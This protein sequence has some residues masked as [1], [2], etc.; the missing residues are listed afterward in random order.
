M[1]D[2]VDLSVTSRKDS[3]VSTRVPS[4]QQDVMSP[5]TTAM[6]IPSALNMP[7]QL[8]FNLNQL[9]PLGLNLQL[10]LPLMAAA[11]GIPQVLV[12]HDLARIT[13]MRRGERE[14]D[15]SGSTTS[16]RSSSVGPGIHFQMPSQPLHPLQVASGNTFKSSSSSSSNP[17]KRKKEQHMSQ[18]SNHFQPPRRS[19]RPR[20]ERSYA[21]SPDIVV[22]YEEEPPK[23]NGVAVLNGNGVD[24]E[25]ES[26][27][28]PGEMPPLPPEINL[29][30][31][32]ECEQKKVLQRL[33]GQLRNEEMKLV[34][35]KKL[36]LSQQMKENVCVSTTTP[37]ASHNGNIPSAKH[38]SSSSPAIPN[39]MGAP[40]QPPPSHHHGSSHNIQSIHLQ[41][42]LTSAGMKGRSSPKLPPST[43]NL[44]T[45]DGH[46]VHGSHHGLGSGGHH[47]H[48]SSRHDFHGMTSSRSHQSNHHSSNASV[49][50][51]KVPSLLKGQPA[52]RGSSGHHIAPPPP[53]MMAPQR[54]PAGSLPHNLLLAHNSLLRGS[55]RNA[56]EVQQ[57]ASNMMMGFGNNPPG[58]VPP[59]HISPANLA[60]KYDRPKEA[61]T[62]SNSSSQQAERR[63][64]LAT[65]APVEREEERETPAQRQAAA[66]LA[67][68]KQLEKTLLQIPPPKPPPPEMNFI[69][70]PNNME[71]LALVGLEFVVDY[72]TRDPS[73][74]IP[75]PDAFTCS[76]CKTD[77]SS[78]WKWDK[79]TKGK[80]ICEQC[81]TSNVKKSLKAEHTNRLKTAFVKALQ[82]EQEI[83]AR[84][85]QG[86]SLSESLNMGAGTGR[87]G[88]TPSPNTADRDRNSPQVVSSSSVDRS[89]SQS[90][91]MRNRTPTQSP[92]LM[93]L[94]LTMPHAQRDR[95]RERERERERAERAERER[96]REIERE[97]IREQREKEREA[98]RE[99]QRELQ[100][101]QQHREREREQ[102]EREREE[103]VRERERREEREH[104]HAVRDAHTMS[105]PQQLREIQQASAQLQQTLQAQVQAAAEQHA[106]RERE[107]QQR[108]QREHERQQRH[109]SQSKSNQSK[110]NYS[111]LQALQAFR[112]SAALG[113]LNLLNLSNLNVM[114]PNPTASTSSGAHSTSQSS[115]HPNQAYSGSKSRNRPSSSRSSAS[116]SKQPRLDAEA[117]KFAS[118]IGMS[119]AAA[120]GS[121]QAGLSASAV[122]AAAALQAAHQQMLR[123]PP[124]QPIP[125]HLLPL[126]PF[127]Y[128]YQMA[129]AQAASGK[130]VTPAS[131]AELQRQAADLQQLQRQIIPGGI[132]QQESKLLD[133]KSLIVLS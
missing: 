22:D 1:D 30:P 40:L 11:A 131:L 84:L 111:N 39:Q 78:S 4:R 93:G 31:E 66:K 121:G 46:G 64:R 86:G 103:R 25:E 29:T 123:M 65:G 18:P 132:T 69:P 51:S 58:A 99:L 70:N 91:A 43:V 117:A 128:P 23:V 113:N 20:I 75:Q 104:R 41:Q 62:S 42:T 125:P 82:Q 83:E 115:N 49:P 12:P 133:Q 98:Q 50:S 108:E 16:S 27:G 110:L 54:S 10:P 53:L 2:V 61:H 114:N 33:R 37:A 34:L 81:V 56:R 19:L 116:A 74:V 6:D 44:S 79:A 119:A 63:H 96:E 32:E 88:S 129:M 7:L 127:L 101:E 95:D 77:F 97:R 28:E 57:S 52:P 21:E 112:D 76:Q 94:P 120:G 8:P 48:S 90:S 100:R 59:P 47:G 107:Q 122:A 3:P 67:L 109:Q 124:S 24:E 5:D 118:A 17:L 38:S 60:D 68:R 89:T 92:G 80:V 9:N 55:S 73:L 35:L 102:R 14:K 45:R 105:I 36:R 126:S 15:E 106:Q 72:I 26:D 130:P 71:F 13:N 87:N 85:A